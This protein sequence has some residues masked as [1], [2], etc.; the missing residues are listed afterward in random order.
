MRDAALAPGLDARRHRATHK[1]LRDRGLDE[2]HSTWLYTY[3]QVYEIL[4]DCFPDE[5]G[6]PD[7]PSVREGCVY[8]LPAADVLDL[9]PATDD[10]TARLR[11]MAERPGWH[12]FAKVKKRGDRTLESLRTEIDRVGRIIAGFPDAARAKDPQ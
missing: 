9:P 11:F 7:E 5:L 3:G 8:G 10:D 12:N 1:I 2:S 6:F 4:E